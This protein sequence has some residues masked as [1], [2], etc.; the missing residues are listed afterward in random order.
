MRAMHVVAR[1]YPSYLLLEHTFRR[2][3]LQTQGLTPNS[4]PGSSVSIPTLIS[5]QAAPALTD[6]GTIFIPFG[7]GCI[8]SCSVTFTVHHATHNGHPSSERNTRTSR[9]RRYPIHAFRRC[10]SP[11]HYPLHDRLGAHDLES[12]SRWARRSR[13]DENLL[14]SAAGADGGSIACVDSPR[15][16]SG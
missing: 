2:R 7:G 16:R 1:V 12:R 4:P 13:D 10:T 3:T 5:W 14:V 9:S 8:F 6:K 11:I 15:A